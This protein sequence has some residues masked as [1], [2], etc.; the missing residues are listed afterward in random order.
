MYIIL[1]LFIKA[2]YLY[3]CMFV[4]FGTSFHGK[5]VF[6][7]IIVSLQSKHWQ[8]AEFDP[9]QSFITKLALSVMIVDHS[10]VF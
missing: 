1:Y 6:T 7:L 3:D 4:K 2:V 9:E 8:D 10:Y 5:T